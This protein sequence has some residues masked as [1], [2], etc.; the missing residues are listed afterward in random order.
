MSDDDSFP[1]RFPFP[2]LREFNFPLRA[3]WPDY[4]DVRYEEHYE[5][6]TDYERVTASGLKITGQG[7]Y[8]SRATRSSVRREVEKLRIL[9]TGLPF[10]S[11]DFIEAAQTLDVRLIMRVRHRDTGELVRV[12]NRQS[13]SWYVFE[14]RD[15]R[16]VLFHCVRHLMYEGLRHEVDESLLYGGIRVSDPHGKDER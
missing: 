8:V 11:L 3:P 2:S 6:F 9:R 1:S 14:Q 5:Y 16:E 4:V 7:S 15:G 13:I 12:E 10:E